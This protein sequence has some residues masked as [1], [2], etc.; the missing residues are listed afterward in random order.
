VR[1][2][3]GGTTLSGSVTTLEEVPS[4]NT[5]TIAI[6]ALVLVVIVLLVLFL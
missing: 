3:P 4:V 1:D 2:R 5:R 6:V